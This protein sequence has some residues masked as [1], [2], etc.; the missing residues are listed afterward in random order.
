M[1]SVTQ[2][3]LK[4]QRICLNEIG[5]RKMFGLWIAFLFA[6]FC[7]WT[8]GTVTVTLLVAVPMLYCQHSVYFALALAIPVP[9][10]S[11]EPPP[12]EN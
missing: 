12:K 2:I 10:I 5:P 11:G 4:I 3:L 1:L 6:M 8:I 7:K 9:S